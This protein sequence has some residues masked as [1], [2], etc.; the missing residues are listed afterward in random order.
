MKYILKWTLKV[1]IQNYE[2][3]AKQNHQTYATKQYNSLGVK[4]IVQIVTEIQIA[5][6]LQIKV[7]SRNPK[8]L[9]EQSARWRSHYESRITESVNTCK[10]V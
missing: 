4:S 8:T 7:W 10:E 1:N 5:A 9:I 2:I 3:R 6:M